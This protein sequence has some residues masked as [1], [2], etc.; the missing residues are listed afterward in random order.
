LALFATHPDQWDLLRAE[1]SLM[2]NAINEVLRYE[3]PLRAF[4]RKAARPTVIADVSVPAGARI[5]VL[6]A[7]A[8]RD[9]RE[10]SD[11]HTFDIRRDANRQL[12]FGHGTHACAGQGLARLEMQAMLGALLD[13]VERIELAG[14]PT[15]ALN[16]I[17]RCHE[18]LPLRLISA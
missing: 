9:E 14:E 5:L 3:S 6:Y 2:P 8:N 12:G 10:W 15:W 18:R 13:R 16:N 17:I 7:S 4:T 11:P 1:P